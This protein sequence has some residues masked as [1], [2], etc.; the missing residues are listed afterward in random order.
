MWFEDCQKT[1]DKLK[2]LYTVAKILA[3]VNFQNPCKLHND[4]INI[5]LETVLYQIEE[6]ID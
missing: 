2:E 5:S 6:G 4:V 3:Y 1:F